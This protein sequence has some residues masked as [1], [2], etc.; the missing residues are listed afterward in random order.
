[1]F[2][3]GHAVDAG[4]WESRGENHG[5]ALWSLALVQHCESHQ[6][7]GPNYL[8]HK[9]RH[10]TLSCVPA[11][12]KPASGQFAAVVS[13]YF[14]RDQLQRKARGTNGD[15]LPLGSGKGHNHVRMKCPCRALLSSSQLFGAK[16]HN[17]TVSEFGGCLKR[18]WWQA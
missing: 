17:S 3:W 6:E 10:P 7:C 13:L 5:P 11:T 2:A 9:M 4:W 12:G 8:G 14:L 18:I 15:Q 16:C 1:M